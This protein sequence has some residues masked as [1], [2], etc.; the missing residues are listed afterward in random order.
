MDIHPFLCG[1]RLLF[2]FCL[3]SLLRFYTS[4]FFVFA[5]VAF[6]MTRPPLSEICLNIDAGPSPA[7]R[8]RTIRCCRNCQ[9]DLPSSSFRPRSSICASCVEL[10]RYEQSAS[11]ELREYSACQAREL[12]RQQELARVHQR[13][14]QLELARQQEL[15][16]ERQREEQQVLA[17]MQEEARSAESHVC[18]G[19]RL[20]LPL[21]HFTGRGRDRRCVACR[22]VVPTRKCSRC[23]NYRPPGDF[24]RRAR[25]CIPCRQSELRRC[26]TCGESFPLTDFPVDGRSC[27]ACCT[28][29][30]TCSL[31]QAE[32]P[33]SVFATG[34]V[35][36]SGTCKACV[37]EFQN[38]TETLYFHTDEVSGGFSA[39]LC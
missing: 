26:L 13:E 30:R 24:V 1:S 17:R 9:L 38:I 5:S 6:N 8:A 21:N 37:E 2:L 22:S 16:W 27:T 25:I 11:Q 31:C 36:T 20:S 29:I 18:G 3:L 19:C 23:K 4:V 15:A 10:S 34:A 35:K 33:G 14:E 32:K 12:A 28:S 7:K 39:F